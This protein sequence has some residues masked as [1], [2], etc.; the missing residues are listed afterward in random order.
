MTRTFDGTD[1][2]DPGD[3]RQQDGPPDDGGRAPGAANTAAPKVLLVD[4]DQALLGLLEEWLAE[5]GCGVVADC[6]TC[7]ESRGPFD[8]VLV[9]VP[10]PRHGGPDLLRRLATRYPGTPIF[11]LS[12][13]FFGGVESDGAVARTLGVD[14]VLPKPLTRATLMAAVERRLRRQA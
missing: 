14:C 5:H 1:R 4:V 6:G 2:P 10:F 3:P 12:S 7:P 9:D 8:L 13:N 11:A